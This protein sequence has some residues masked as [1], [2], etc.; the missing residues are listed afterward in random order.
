MNILYT[1]PAGR[2]IWNRFSQPPN[3]ILEPRPN[4][5]RQFDRTE[6]APFLF[7]CPGSSTIVCFVAVAT[8]AGVNGNS[9]GVTARQSAS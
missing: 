6:N 8:A 1:R 7:H 3:V 9:C 4:V 5:V 2:H